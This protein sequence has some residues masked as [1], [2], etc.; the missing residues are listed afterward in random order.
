MFI[1]DLE[2]GL[3]YRAYMKK[4]QLW[5]RACNFPCQWRGQIMK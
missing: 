5:H 2:L 3:D 4:K 1:V